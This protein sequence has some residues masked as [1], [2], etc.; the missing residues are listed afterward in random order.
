HSGGHF[1][2]P[3]PDLDQRSGFPNLT[4]LY[5]RLYQS[6]DRALGEI[7]DSVPDDAIVVLFSIEGTSLNNR[8]V[9]GLAILPELMFRHSFPGEIGFDLGRSA[10]PPA[11]QPARANWVEQL[12]DFRVRTNPF[13]S[14]I[15]Q[16]LGSRLAVRIERL[17][18]V[19]PTLFSPSLFTHLNCYQPPVW[20]SPYW[21]YMKAFALPTFLQGYVRLNIRGRDPGGIV[22]P[23]D[24]ARECSD[25]RELLYDL[26]DA[27]SGRPLVSHIVTRSE[28][29]LFEEAGPDPDLFVHWSQDVRDTAVST[30]FG[31]LGPV[32]YYQSGNHNLDGFMIAS[33][34]GIEP[35]SFAGE[36]DIFDVVPTI[37]A[38]LAVTPP[39]YLAGKSLIVQSAELKECVPA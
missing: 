24:Y 21:P 6:A 34:N 31:Q 9:P 7:L 23:H 29:Q 22:E 35:S 36:G 4:D 25:L 27:V 10:V 15:R 37:L 19:R 16:A 30:R 32:P 1:L 2:Y 26:R 18:G 33:G 5:E 11:V 20:Y 8:D 12:W 3:H 14:C 39:D 28:E 17:L 38:M 13:M